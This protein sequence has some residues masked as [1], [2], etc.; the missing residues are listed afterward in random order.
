MR[1]RYQL[2]R[3]INKYY[4]WAVSRIKLKTVY[5]LVLLRF[6]SYT[7]TGCN[8]LAQLLFIWL[9]AL[10]LCLHLSE[11]MH[12]MYQAVHATEML[13]VIFLDRGWPDTICLT[14]RA[15]QSALLL[16]Q[17]L[18]QASVEYLDYN[19]SVVT[20]LAGI[21]WLRELPE[22]SS[23]RNNALSTVYLDVRTYSYL[24]KAEWKNFGRECMITVE[25]FC[26]NN[27]SVLPYLHF[28]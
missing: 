9:R 11:H 7:W 12:T 1:I 17:Q 8:K 22:H 19:T 25:K 24:Y 27:T 21:I 28:M 14:F 16:E 6:R 20:N 2:L 5:F 10:S 3:L 15:K 18:K 23:Y 4:I 26:I 13:T